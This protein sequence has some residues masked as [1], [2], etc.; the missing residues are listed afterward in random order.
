MSHENE[1]D[2]FLE[3]VSA[4]LGACLVVCLT[5]CDGYNGLYDMTTPRV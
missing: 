2:T 1:T 3:R 5:V 4:F